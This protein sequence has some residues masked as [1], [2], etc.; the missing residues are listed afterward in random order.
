M[1]NNNLMITRELW[2][3]QANQLIASCHYNL[4]TLSWA[5]GFRLLERE[6]SLD[7]KNLSI[8]LKAKMPSVSLL[9]ISQLLQIQYIL[10]LLKAFGFFYL[11]KAK[12]HTLNHSMGRKKKNALAL[13]VNSLAWTP[14]LWCLACFLIIIWAKCNFII[15]STSIAIYLLA[16]TCSTYVSPWFHRM[17]L[18]NTSTFC[19]PDN[20]S[21]NASL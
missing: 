19:H 6:L 17:E 4:D 12:I 18:H 16:V 21:E 2:S 1:R 11:N 14:P 7:L 5:W 13:E 10:D 20:Q 15:F 3:M 9:G 8:Y